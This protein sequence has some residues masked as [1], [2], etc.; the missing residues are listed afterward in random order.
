MNQPPPYVEGHQ[1]LA[2]KTVVVTAA[3]GTGIG[4]A[5]AKRCLEE[6]ATVLISD[7]HP[8]RL[9]ESADTLRKLANDRVHTQICNVTQ[10]DDVQALIQAGISELG[11]ID[12]LMNNAGLGGTANV[13]DMTDDQWH[14]VLDITLTGTFRMTR[15]VLPHMT[16][17][18]SGVI[19]NNA[20]VLAW[21]AQ[22]GQAHYAAA[23]AGVMALTRCSALEV[24]D[25]GVRINAVSPS[26][27]MHP[28]LSKVTPPGLLE[29]L[30]DREAFKRGAEPWEV[31][32]VMVFLA[33]DYS[34]YMTG[35]VVA[36]SSQRA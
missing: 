8:R 34:S 2:S 24:A 33:S 28:F 14:S 12:V 22:E 10:E 3:A 23:K 4:F 15:A 6:G 20:S 32:N 16:E 13:V 29:E 35:E 27:A 11:R 7:I 31:A 19:V 9:E 25:S 17:R 36:V 1:L 30:T 26:L 18:G 21:R 5:V